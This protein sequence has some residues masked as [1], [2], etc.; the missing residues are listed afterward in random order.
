MFFVK[1]CLKIKSIQ[2]AAKFCNFVNFI[3]PV[4]SVIR[5]LLFGQP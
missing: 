1:K 5:F 4:T 2:I 3:Q